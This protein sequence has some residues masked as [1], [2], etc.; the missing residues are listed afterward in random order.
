M[1]TITASPPILDSSGKPANGLIYVTASR[2]FDSAAG[3]NTTAKSTIR[4]ADGVP[5]HNG[6]PWTVP[7][8]PEGVYLSIE[9]DL[10]GDAMR[11]VSY[12]TV[13]DVPAM[14]YAEL[15]FNRGHGEG[16]TGPYWWILPTGQDFP[17][18]AIDGDWGYDPATDDVWR[19]DA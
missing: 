15:L 7:A 5:T 6:S 16:G 11:R 3:H 8:T 4:V 13:P 19:Y 18:E 17:P 2:A 9:Q 10:D 1:P 14:S 12:V